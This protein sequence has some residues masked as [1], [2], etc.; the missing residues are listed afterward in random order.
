MIA[1]FLGA[2]FSKW[3]AGLP[4][5]SELFDFNIE[6][7]G[8][9]GSHYLNDIR[10]LK[11]VW[12]SSHPDGRAEHFVADTLHSNKRVGSLV[13][14]YIV[15]RLSERFI[16]KE[17]HARKWR[18]HSLMINENRRFRLPEIEKAQEF[19][20]RYYSPALAGIITTD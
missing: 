14:R 20:L 19:L 6:L 3:A 10:E 12:D 15:R 9:R 7:W 13:Q 11:G 5:A 18:R 17:W 8:P 2:G 16:W 4:L 1:L